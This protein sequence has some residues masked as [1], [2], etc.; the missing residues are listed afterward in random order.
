MCDRLADI[1]GYLCDECFEELV[2]LGHPVNLDHFMRTPKK[3][4]ID[5]A[6]ARAYYNAIFVKRED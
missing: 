2:A 1:H 3:P 6:A 4:I 5:Q